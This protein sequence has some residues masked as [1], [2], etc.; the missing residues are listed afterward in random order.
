LFESNGG[1]EIFQLSGDF[2]GGACGFGLFSEQA[3]VLAGGFDFRF[4]VGFGHPFEAHE[5][6]EVVLGGGECF[7]DLRN[8]AGVC[9][10]SVCGGEFAEEFFEVFAGFGESGAVNSGLGQFESECIAKFVCVVREEFESLLQLLRGSGPLD[11]AGEVATGLQM[12]ADLIHAS[13]GFTGAE[14]IE[15]SGEGDD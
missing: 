11:L 9:G 13:V 15:E 3:V 5:P 1:F 7:A 14:M 8:K 12:G 2:G 6:S 10:L 4:P